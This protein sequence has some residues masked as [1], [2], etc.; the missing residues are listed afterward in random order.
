MEDLHISDKSMNVAFSDGVLDL[1]TVLPH[2]DGVSKGIPFIRFIIEEGLSPEEV[3][4][5][6]H[7][8]EY[9]MKQWLPLLDVLSLFDPT[10]ENSGFKDVVNRTNNALESYNRRFNGKFKKGVP[11][12]PEFIGVV[13]KESRYYATKLANIRRGLETRPVYQELPIPKIPQTYTD[14]VA[15]IGFV[16]V[17]VKFGAGETFHVGG[18][19]PKEKRNK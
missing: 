11:S 10:G 12:L 5:W 1:L 15:M 4:L 9:W 2:D 7:F 14:Y 18:Y 8:W 3:K 16:H 13:E 19:K 17:T 6:E